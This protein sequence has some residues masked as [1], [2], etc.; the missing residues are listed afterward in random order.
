MGK[1]IRPTINTKFHIDFDWW[2]QREENFRV[3]LWSH[4]CTECQTV[5]ESYQG[6]EEIDWVD[7]D[8]AEVTRVDALWHSLQTCCSKKLNFITDQTPFIDAIFRV[9]LANGN[10]PLSPLEMYDFIGKRSP[11]TI[12]RMLTRGDIHRGIKPVQEPEI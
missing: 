4:L 12:L 9:F 6:T 10:T 11:S 7:P 3:C 2:K 5:Y 8:T 1:W